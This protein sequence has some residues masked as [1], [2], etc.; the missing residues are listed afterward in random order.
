MWNEIYAAE[1][2]D[3][4]QRLTHYTLFVIKMGRKQDIPKHAD[5]GD[6]FTK[7]NLTHII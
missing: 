5:K 2:P 3:E 1:N 4:Y 6:K 7:M